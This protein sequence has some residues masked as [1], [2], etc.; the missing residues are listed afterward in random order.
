MRDGGI[1]KLTL[2]ITFNIVWFLIM[3]SFAVDPYLL[4]EVV[5]DPEDDDQISP[6]WERIAK[7]FS[8]RQAAFY[9]PLLIFFPFSDANRNHFLHAI[10]VVALALGLSP[11]MKSPWTQDT[12]LD[13]LDVEGIISG[14]VAVI[15][16]GILLLTTSRK[17]VLLTFL[18]TDYIDLIAVH[19]VAGWWCVAMS[20]IHS[21]AYV[22]Y[23]IV[24]GGARKLLSECFPTKRC[25]REGHWEQCLNLGGMVNFFGL[26]GT[27]A[28]LVLAFFSREA[29]RRSIFERFYTIHL[30]TSA[31]FI[32]FVALHDYGAILLAFAG[33][34]FY[35]CD[36]YNARR[37]RSH[38]SSFTAE[39]ITD[40]IV[41]LKWN[42]PAQNTLMPGTRFVYVRIGNIS[43]SEWHPISCV[44]VCD[45]MYT[46]VKG[47][48]DWS[49]SLCDLVLSQEPLQITIEGPFG[50]S[51]LGEDVPRN[52]IIIAGGVGI[53]P[54]I[55]FLCNIPNT[56][57]WSKIKLIWAVRSNE[58]CA[59]SEIID[60]EAISSVADVSIF[61][62]SQVKT[63]RTFQSSEHEGISVSKNNAANFK[64]SPL[65]SFAMLIISTALI[66]GCAWAS[67]H[68]HDKL[69]DDLYDDISTLMKY[70]FALRVAPVSISIGFAI[71]S[72]FGLFLIQQIKKS[73]GHLKKSD[74]TI[75]LAGEDC[76]PYGPPQ[77]HNSRPN[78]KEDIESEIESGP[79]K[80]EV[81]GPKRMIDDV[82]Q[83]V[84]GLR[85]KKHDIKLHVHDSA[86]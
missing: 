81:C 27:I 49:S 32:F 3:I 22:I 4:Y 39:P 74:W 28:V 25:F 64:I 60:F 38:H 42:A 68:I 13:F 73:Y 65:I 44:Q 40:N 82:V 15:Y 31:I 58:Y 18:G 23:Y 8:F 84:E 47:L 77:V 1:T 66:T 69:Y 46:F 20:I 36:R 2:L 41:M 70:V 9:L 45:R 71:I 63:E 43:A 85:L 52:L 29:I 57:S 79:M 59:L 80:I 76:T 62:T 37:T 33:L 12:V 5:T 14:R 67:S 17:S 34:A 6:F 55:D 16:L 54:F 19:R 21:L 26:I 35:A 78:L 75:Q 30:I 48:G 7:S 56:S 61:I 10:G 11:L 24:E 53:S 72:S 86:I 83:T 51:I 50:S